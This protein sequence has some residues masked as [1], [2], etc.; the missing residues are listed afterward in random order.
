MDKIKLHVQEFRQK[1]EQVIK[2]KDIKA[3]KE[4]ASDIGQLDFELRNL[5]TG[6]AMDI[7]YLQQINENFQSFHW[8]DS[9]KARTLCNTGMQLASN[10]K[11]NQV[12]PV[13]I[14][15]VGL[16]DQGEAEQFLGKLTR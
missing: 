13:L 12:R 7:A 6:G 10:G 9:N 5:V 2:E 14:E 11:A 4:L 1:I 15:L 8:K 3:A 16:M